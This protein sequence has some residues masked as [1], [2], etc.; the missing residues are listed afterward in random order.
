MYTGGEDVFNL[1][2]MA[3][4]LLIIKKCVFNFET[5]AK[6]LLP[7]ANCCFQMSPRVD[8]SLFLFEEGWGRFIFV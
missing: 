1:W 5:E 8:D 6:L 2:L 4:S 7:N 3:Y